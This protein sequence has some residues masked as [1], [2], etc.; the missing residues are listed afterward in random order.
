[1]GAGVLC[2]WFTVEAANTDPEKYP[3]HCR[4]SINELS[5][6]MDDGWMDGWMMDRLMDG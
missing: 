1:M 5:K 4:G 3:T 2:V 6:W